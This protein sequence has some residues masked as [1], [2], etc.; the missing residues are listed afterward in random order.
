MR[1]LGALDVGSV[2]VHEDVPYHFQRFVVLVPLLVEL[3]KKRSSL[4]S[5]DELGLVLEMSSHG[6]DKAGVE[7]IAKLVQNHVVR[8]PDKLA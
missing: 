4:S 3:F 8:V 7:L 2:H 1:L 5:L 6:G